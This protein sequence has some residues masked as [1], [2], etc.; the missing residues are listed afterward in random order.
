MNQ[1]EI[2]R[3]ARHFRSAGHE[4]VATAG[5][6][7][8]ALVNTCTVTSEAASDS[9]AAI[10]RINRSGV[11]TIIATGCWATIE[12]EAAARLPGVTHIIPNQDKDEMVPDLLGLPR[13]DFDLEPIARMPLPGMHARTRAFLKVQDGCNNAC[14]YCITRLARGNSRSIPMEKVLKDVKA[15]LAGGTQEIV[16]TGVH[17]GAWGLDLSPR[18][19][20]SDLVT[21]LLAHNAIPR[22]R[23]SS[24]EPWDLEPAFFEM[25]RYPALCPHL[26]IPLQSGSTAVLGR[27]NRKIT[28]EAYKRLVEKARASIPGIAI[29]TDIIVGFPGETEEEFNESL[30][31]IRSMNFA[32]GHV[33]TYSARPGTAAA[34]MPGRIHGQVARL[35]SQ[36]VRTVLAD[37]AHCY[38][39][40]YLGRTVKVLWESA[41][42]IS[43]MGWRMEGLTGNYLRVSAMATEPRPNQI[44]MVNIHSVDGDILEGEILLGKAS[45]SPGASTS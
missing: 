5:E 17:L 38:R 43:D 27:M 3:I 33:F 41:S 34:S 6:A 11:P 32:G 25:W 4:I 22:L 12:P 35:R 44:D 36:Q 18:Q 13:E 10:R 14:S 2:E 20:L 37:S 15:A 16:L 9:R 19:G 39:Q 28:L 1:A 30:A 23:L 31:F 40:D 42:Q 8:L 21:S 45:M 26:H 7:D 24:L 29:T